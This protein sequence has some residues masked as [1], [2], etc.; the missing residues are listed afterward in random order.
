LLAAAADDVAGT[1]AV[2]V[3]DVVTKVAVAVAAVADAA[4]AELASVESD[5][6]ELVTVLW[7]LD[8]GTAEPD[9]VRAVALKA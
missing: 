1:T 2:E 3:A 9:D 6:L 7:E 8:T 4:V 5:K